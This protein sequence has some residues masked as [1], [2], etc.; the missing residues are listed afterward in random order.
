[1][2]NVTLPCLI[3]ELMNSRENRK[4]ETESITVIQHFIRYSYTIYLL[5]LDL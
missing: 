5:D 3:F 2:L 4:S 1:M